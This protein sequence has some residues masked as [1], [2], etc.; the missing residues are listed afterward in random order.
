M[1]TYSI[2]K[3]L[4]HGTWWVYTAVLWMII[5]SKPNQTINRMEIR[6]KGHVHIQTTTN[7]IPS[8]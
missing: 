5:K 1:E 2:V 6:V 8:A 7:L 4:T 3:A